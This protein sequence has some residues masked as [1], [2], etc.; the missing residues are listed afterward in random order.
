MSLIL[1]TST[2]TP[3]PSLQAHWPPTECAEAQLVHEN[4]QT[5]LTRSW[6]FTTASQKKCNA[7][8]KTKKAILLQKMQFAA[9]IL[10][11]NLRSKD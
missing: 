4:D 9:N 11:A 3:L 8:R 6:V 2:N 1:G 10:T 7:Q 5:V